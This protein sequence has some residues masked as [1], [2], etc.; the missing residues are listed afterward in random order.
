MYKIILSLLIA[1]SVYAGEDIM[2]VVDFNKIHSN[3]RCVS[4]LLSAKEYQMKGT[5]QYTDST[6]KYQAM[7]LSKRYLEQHERCMKGAEQ[8]Y[9]NTPNMFQTTE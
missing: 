6:T 1:T 2:K 7:K 5:A 4:L 9:S 3:D 8:R